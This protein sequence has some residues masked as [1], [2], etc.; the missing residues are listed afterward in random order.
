[1]TQHNGKFVAYYRA[2]TSRQGR[3][4]LGMDALAAA[5]RKGN[6]LGGNRGTML[7]KRMRAASKAALHKRADA[8]FANIAPAIA[9]LQA[10]GAASLRAIAA[11]L[12]AQGI[13]TS[14]GSGEWT[15]V[16]VQRVLERV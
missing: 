2:S 5:K 4:R 12:N 10:A 9:K 7:M 14:R 8:P 16:Q 3:C 13:P 15:A 6:K 1:M 11:G